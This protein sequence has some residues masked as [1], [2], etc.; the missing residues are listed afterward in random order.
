M[1][2]IKPREKCVCGKEFERVGNYWQCG[3]ERNDD[4]HI[5]SGPYDDPT[6]EK[7]DSMVRKM[8]A[9]TTMTMAEME[10]R[11]TRI[12][13]AKKDIARLDDE[14]MSGWRIETKNRF[15]EFRDLLDL[16]LFQMTLGGY[17]ES[18]RQVIHDECAALGVEVEK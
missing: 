7:I 10:E 1:S 13:K 16:G 2:Q 4:G 18:M 5:I 15:F 8:R 14:N 11:L 3:S 17:I 9:R 6:G 12:Q